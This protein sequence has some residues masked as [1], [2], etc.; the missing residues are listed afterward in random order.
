M[1][2]AH[3]CVQCGQ[4][5]DLCAEHWGEGGWTQTTREKYAIRIE[6]CPTCAVQWVGQRRT[7]ADVIAEV[8]R[9]AA[10]Y[11]GVGGLTLTGGEPTFQPLFAEALL[12]LARASRMTTALETSGHTRWKILERL[13]PYLDHILYDFK[14]IDPDKHRAHTGVDN[15]LILSNLRRLVEVGAPLSIRVPVIPGFNADDLGAMADWLRGVGCH[16]LTLLP[17][18][19]FGRAK[20]AGLGRE[21]SWD[22]HTPLSADTVQGLADDVRS[23]GL[24]VHVG[25]DEYS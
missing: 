4:F 9:D 18:H 8:Q 16:S 7:A 15:E 17:Y 21:Y 3:R 23:R 13:L 11:D 6:V 19:T 12:R 14:H 10:F 22:S 25:G 5:D 24:T 20:Y 1:L 2:S